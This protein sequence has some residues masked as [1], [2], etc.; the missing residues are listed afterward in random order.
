MLATVFI[1]AALTTWPV[2]ALILVV[3][4]GVSAYYLRHRYRSEL[5]IAQIVPPAHRERLDRIVDGDLQMVVVAGLTAAGLML[6]FG[7]H[8]LH[9]VISRWT[10][11]LVGVAAASV[12]VSSLSDWYVI[13][14]RITGMLGSRPCRFEDERHPRFPHTWRD[15]TRW[16][17]VHRLL[18][19]FGFRFGLSYALTL[20]ARHWITF[21]F[22]TDIVTGAALGFAATYQKA[23]PAAG[24]QAGHPTMIVGQTVVHDE[25]TRGPRRITI[26]G[27]VIRVPFMKQAVPTGELSAREWVYDVALEG[28]QLVVAASREARSLPRSDDGRLIYERRPHKILLRDIAGVRAADPPFS[29]C[30]SRCSGINWYCI[31]NPRCFEAK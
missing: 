3:A 19:L 6:G 2:A 7:I 23:I 21:R 14:P 16:W 31:E 4:S 24:F 8:P 15:T 26:F 13:L 17:L 28:V 20:V 29:G 22:G 25:T 12:Y 27:R 18:A 30:A 10:P 11:L 9:I 5:T 1:A